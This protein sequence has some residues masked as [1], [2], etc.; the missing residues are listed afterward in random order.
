LL[1]ESLFL[2]N[3]SLRGFDKPNNIAHSEHLADKP[4]GIERLQLIGLFPHPDELDRHTR[5]L[6]DRKRGTATS[7]AI[8]LRQDHAVELESL[9]ERPGARDRVLPSQ[10]VTYEEDLV[11]LDLFLDLLQLTH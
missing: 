3:R 4:L 2:I 9:V 1:T 5:D 10:R 11:R 7:I 8:Q 6:P